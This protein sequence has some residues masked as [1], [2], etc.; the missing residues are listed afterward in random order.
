MTNR[1]SSSRPKDD[2]DERIQARVQS[3]AYASAED[4]VR[5]GLAALAREEQALFED[6]RRRI[7]ES[8]DESGE[9]IRADDVFAEVRALSCAG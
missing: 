1:R 4:V 8:I 3:G 7:A 2:L 5:A 9:D 6:M